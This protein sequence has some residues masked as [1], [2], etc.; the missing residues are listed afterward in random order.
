MDFPQDGYSWE[1]TFRCVHLSSD[2]REVM[3]ALPR[4]LS[5][6]TPQDTKDSLGVDFP[7]MDVFHDLRI[8][9]ARDW[10][11][12]TALTVSLDKVGAKLC[13]LSVWSG[14]NEQQ[15]IKCRVSNL[16][17]DQA[18]A[19]TQDL[20]LLAGVTDATVEYILFRAKTVPG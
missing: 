16:S 14:D 9:C 15:Y 1:L 13:S 5:T 8:I 18:S 11:V 6:S 2:E 4:S 7:D 19:V 12:L 20:S 10:N 3:T 17:S